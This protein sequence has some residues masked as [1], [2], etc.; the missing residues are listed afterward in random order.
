MNSNSMTF[1]NLEQIDQ[2]KNVTL[3][4]PRE[5]SI[6]L[7]THEL[8]MYPSC[9]NNTPMLLLVQ[10]FSSEYQ[11]KVFRKP[12]FRW[13]LSHVSTKKTEIIKILQPYVHPMNGKLDK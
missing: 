11:L 2:I 7:H 1:Y 13:I 9:R 3:T 5:A 8:T 6:G 4:M 12:L 10:L